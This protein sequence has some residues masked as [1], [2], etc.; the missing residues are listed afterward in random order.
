MERERE[1]HE[2]TQILQEWRDGD[3]NAAERLFPLVYNELKR[4]ARTFLNRERQDHTLQPTALV[5]EAYLRMVDQTSLAVENRLHFYAVAAR[6]MRQILV[7]HARQHKAEKRGGAAERFAIDDLDVLPAQSAADLLELDE[8]LQKL[9]TLDNR[10]CR[11]VDMRFFGGLKED[12]IAEVLGVN[13]KT[14]RRD[15]QF[16][17]LWLFRELS[18]NA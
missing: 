9:E 6:V 4:Q 13:E 7:D 3:K 18:Q 8:A 12:E 16:A 11:V 14:V 10:K 2:V 1:N 15:W 5:H 17:K